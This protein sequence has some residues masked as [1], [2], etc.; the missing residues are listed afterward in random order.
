[1]DAILKDIRYSL[2]MIR[3]TPGTSAVAVVALAMG[4]GLTTLMF[5]IVYGA[6]MRGLPFDDPG[7]IVMVQRINPERGISG[8]WIPVHD[9]EDLRAQQR[10]FEV[11]GAYYQATLN[12]S[13]IGEAPERLDGA[14]ITPAL[15]GAFGERPVIGRW[16][17]EADDAPGA[18]PVMMVGWQVWQ[19]RFAGDPDVIGQVVRVNGLPTT[20]VGVMPRGFGFPFSQNAWLPFGLRATELERG[21]EPSVAVTGRLRDGVTMDMARADLAGI[22]R[23]LETE[24][25][26][27][28]EG[29]SVSVDD[30][31]SEGI[32]SEAPVLLFTMFGAV[33]F[34]LLIACAN[35]TNVLMGRAM[36]RSREV[37]VRTALGASRVRIALQFLVE[38]FALAAVGAI[39]GLAIAGIGI[40]M[41]NAAIVGADP[42]FWLSIRLDGTAFLC[43]LGATFLAAF[44]AGAVPALQAARAD[45]NEILKDEARG[46]SSFR[47]GRASRGLVMFE[48]ALSV[49][50]LLGA[51][52]MIKSV[53][54]LN[55]FDL[56]YG[57]DRMFTARML[58]P[59]DVYEDQASRIRFADDLEQ[60]LAALPGVDGVALSTSPP[61]LGAGGNSFAI[62]S[63][64][65]P[66]AERWP[67]ETSVYVSA[68]YFSTLSASMLRGRDFNDGD[69]S[70]SLPVVIVNQA[71]ER[72]HLNG[73]GLGMRIRLAGPDSSWRT[74][75]GIAPDITVGSV[76]DESPETLFLPLAQIPTRAL[77]VVIRTSTD[78]TSLY[79]PVRETVNEIDPDLPI[80]QAGAL[81]DVIAA[82]NWYYGVF[83]ALFGSFGFAALFL[84]SVGLYGVMA[85]SVSQ[86]TREMGVRMAV[87]A[88]PR[89]VLQLV[90]GQ[91]MI[92][93]GIGLGAGIVLGLALSN[94]LANFLF[95][96]EARD[97]LVLSAILAV[98]AVT[99][100][101]ACWVP[102]RRATS[103]DPLVAL[104]Y[105]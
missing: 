92:Q 94:L 2:R 69:R 70:G 6:L 46:S 38:S 85:F 56:G 11:L 31:A 55:T 67:S 98:L 28:N 81:S 74:I 83:G 32:G 61:G 16:L 43:A 52:L 60:R 27:T 84:A 105:E 80:Y 42:P 30:Y 68:G 21:R 5:S 87:G 88:A 22:A 78:P 96:V 77:T 33:V 89:D 103:V 35:V 25:P 48:M 76:E 63:V 59:A 57:A 104:R 41:F 79:R 75:V 45:T 49:A 102:A 101:L 20:I 4:I 1:M 26:A 64:T 19:D 36:L 40:R 29:W 7:E 72:K 47:Q 37:A 3:K 73:D 13:G 71:F 62:E 93:T 90:I 17:E 15:F 66:E 12:L 23:I 91:G 51:G 86:R 95:R 44:A 65:D 24:Y 100:L 34:V 8:N 99:A 18:A 97:P 82:D 14:R 58:L 9:F 50:L 10:S 54:R 39:V 53:I